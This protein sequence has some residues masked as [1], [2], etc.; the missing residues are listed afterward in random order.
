MTL[1]EREQEALRGQQCPFWGSFAQQN[2]QAFIGFNRLLNAHR[3]DTIIELGTHDGG[4]STFFALYTFLAGAPASSPNSAE[5]TLYKNQTHHRTPKRFVTFDNVIRDST[6]I[7]VIKHLGGHFVQTDTLTDQYSI[8]RIR[9]IIED[10]AGGTVLL[11]CDGG[12]KKLELDLYGGSLK[13]GDFVMLHDWARDEAAFE[14]NKRANVW[15]SWESRWEDGTGQGQQFGIKD[16]CATHGITPI[17][18][19]EFDRAAWFCGTKL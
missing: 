1:L 13:P 14:A 5:P 2:P 12:N 9:S 10:P 17:Y 8:D 7:N 19:E 11:L 4:L 18:A 3:F 16:L 15:H 6:A